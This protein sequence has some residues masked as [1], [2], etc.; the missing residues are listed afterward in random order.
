MEE[1]NEF[2]EPQK[3]KSKTQCC[4]ECNEYRPLRDELCMVCQTK[5][6]M[7]LCTELAEQYFGK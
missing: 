5:Y 3:K 2:A 6:M 1:L 4:F 7:K